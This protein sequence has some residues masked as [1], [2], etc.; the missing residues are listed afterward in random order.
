M[1]TPGGVPDDSEVCGT[2]ERD[3]AFPL[4]LVA[5]SVEAWIRSGSVVSAEGLSSEGLLNCGGKPVLG[6]GL[7]P[8]ISMVFSRPGM[9]GEV[10]GGGEESNVK[11][12][13]KG[14]VPAGKGA[15]EDG[16]LVTSTEGRLLCE[17]SSGPLFQ[18]VVI[19]TRGNP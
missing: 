8:N 17:T 9:R 5:G 18:R 4:G 15:G 16:E 3:S 19:S 11:G 2:E 14:E 12:A 10:P 7:A 13:G 1:L 6:S